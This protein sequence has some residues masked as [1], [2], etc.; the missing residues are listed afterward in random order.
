MKKW[1]IHIRRVKDKGW[2]IYVKHQNLEEEKSE[3][4]IE[5]RG[6]F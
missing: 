3:S 5:N 4:G 2:K 1:N 6:D